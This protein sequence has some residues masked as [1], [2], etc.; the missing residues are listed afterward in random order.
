MSVFGSPCQHDLQTCN[1]RVGMDAA[2]LP[3]LTE[4][5]PGKK[6]LGYVCVQC[7]AEDL[8]HKG[9]HSFLICPHMH[10]YLV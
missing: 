3:S 7:T 6:E 5:N 9:C 8:A 4:A 2:L 10:V 1:L